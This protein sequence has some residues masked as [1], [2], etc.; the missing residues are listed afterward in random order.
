MSESV[1]TKHVYFVRHGETVWN[2]TKQS[3]G[4]DTPLNERGHYQAKV[5]AGRVKA[6]K[7]E[8]L[9]TSDMVRAIETGTYISDALGLKAEASSLFR[10]WMTPASVRGK[11]FDTPEYQKFFNE[12]NNNFDDP[13]WRYEDVENYADLNK[14]MIKVLELL[15]NEPSDKVVVV[16]HGKFLRLFLGFVLH[17]GN[18][19]AANWLSFVNRVTLTNTGITLFEVNDNKWSLITWNDHAH[20]AE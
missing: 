13:N 6:L 8:K 20:F 10:E 17:D 11:T 19:S 3:Q 5:L 16:T 14:R 1:K 7:A 4:M 15:K 12:L 2:V 9:Y 18:L